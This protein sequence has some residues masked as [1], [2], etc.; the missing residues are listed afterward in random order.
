MLVLLCHYRN[1]LFKIKLLNN[2]ISN[3]RF[4][5]SII[6]PSITFIYFLP[7]PNSKK[8]LTYGGWQKEILG[9]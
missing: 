7:L 4:Q 2:E 5:Q 6:Q 9:N 8:V 3:L 1:F